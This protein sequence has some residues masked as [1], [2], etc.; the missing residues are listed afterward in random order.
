MH[1]TES[2]GFEIKM[3]NESK[4]KTENNNNNI[5]IECVW[6]RKKNTETSFSTKYY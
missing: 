1:N 3:Q 6:T 5:I 2:K 4:F